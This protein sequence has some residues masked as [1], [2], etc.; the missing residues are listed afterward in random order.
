MFV[1]INTGS[2]E[3]QPDPQCICNALAWNPG[4]IGVKLAGHVSEFRSFVGRGF[5]LVCRG[6]PHTSPCT[7]PRNVFNSLGVSG[8]SVCL[9]DVRITNMYIYIYIDIDRWMDG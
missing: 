6:K 5:L 2:V 9:L 1:V 4:S 7:C 3:E 8:A